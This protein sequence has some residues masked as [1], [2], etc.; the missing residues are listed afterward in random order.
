MAL[1]T[2]SLKA[3]Y[4]IVNLVLTK[5]D[6]DYFFLSTMA[7]AVISLKYS[8]ILQHYTVSSTGP[9]GFLTEREMQDLNPRI[10]NSATWWCAAIFHHLS[11]LENS[12]SS[13]RDSTQLWIFSK[14]FPE[15]FYPSPPPPS[16]NLTHFWLTSMH[17]Y[18]THALLE[19][20]TYRIF[21]TLTL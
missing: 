6:L 1:W 7:S 11:D 15:T 16:P 10:A 14:T 19:P 9:R 13:P 21:W 2:G 4:G 3:K 20:A 8:E 12:F 17:L 18:S 5:N